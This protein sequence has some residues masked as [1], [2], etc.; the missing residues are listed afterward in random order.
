MLLEEFG[1]AGWNP[2]RHYDAMAHA[3]LAAGAAGAM[4]YE[5]GVR[6]LAPELSFQSLPLRDVLDVPAD[7]RFFAPLPDLVKDWPAQSTGIDPSPSGFTYGSIYTGTPFPAT[8]AIALGL[9][10]RMGEGMERSVESQSTYVVIPSAPGSIKDG[11]E[12]VGKVIGQLNADRVAFGILQEDCLAV[13][14]RDL[15]VLILPLGFPA[16]S[17]ELI[18]RIRHS[19]TA[20]LDASQPG[21]DLSPLIHHIGVAPSDVNLMVR[22]VPGGHL[23][24]LESSKAE[25]S[26]HLSIEPGKDVALGLTDFAMVRQRGAAIDWIE[27]SG[28]VSRGD[29]PICSIHNGRAILISSHG[30][31]LA[32]TRSMR[33]LAAEPTQIRFPRKISSLAI[34]E[35][36][37]RISIPVQES[38]E[39]S[40]L[41]LDDQLVQYVVEVNF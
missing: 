24:V 41:E 36:G 14:P 18:A 31:D 26:V 4:S 16:K 6:W 35:D 7:P 40:T 20:V 27:A 28:E 11:M 22:D 39:E 8:A 10:S 21:W 23:Y 5:W 32:V 17:P 13:P 12:K 15:H 3:A 38:G 9:L 29:S 19:G 1:H 2:V 34:I 33:V 25:P 30:D 37:R